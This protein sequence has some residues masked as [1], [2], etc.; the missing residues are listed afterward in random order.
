MRTLDRIVHRASEQMASSWARG[1][2]R[3]PTADSPLDGEKHTS[4]TFS[5]PSNTDTAGG[6]SLSSSP[7]V[8]PLL[9]LDEAGAALRS[10]WNCA[11]LG[12]RRGGERGTS[13][14]V[15][16]TEAAGRASEG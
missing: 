2:A 4:R 15:H 7:D 1:R 13:P 5:G 12:V 14:A 3:A 16:A 11:M 10:A 6:V 9:A 8:A